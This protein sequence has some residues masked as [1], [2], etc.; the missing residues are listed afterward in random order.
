MIDDAAR[1][2]EHDRSRTPWWTPHPVVLEINTWVWLGEIAERDGRT[3]RLGDVPPRDW[4]YLAAWGLDAVWL[5]GVWERSPLG[6]QITLADPVVMDE[7]RRALPGLTS[8]DVAGSPYSI[9][10]YEVDARLGGRA[11]LAAARAAL[12]ARGIALILD[13]VPNHV[14][15]DHPWVAESPS[16]FI[17]GNAIDLAR[18]PD[19]FIALGGVVLARGRDPWFQPWKDTVQLNAFDPGLRAAA[20]A[21]LLDI[22]TQCDG[23]RCDMA[24]LV[25]SDVFGRTWAGRAGSPPAAEFWTEMIDPVRGARPDFRFIAEAYWEREWA[26][27][28]LDFDWCYDKGLYDRLV[29]GDAESV[30]RDLRTEH[31]RGMRLVRFIENHDEPRAAAMLPA[32]RHRAA[33]VIA[34]MQSGMRL[35]H[36]GQFEGRRVRIPV[37]LARRPAEQPDEQILLFHRRLLATLRSRP[38]HEGEWRLCETA[39]WEDHIAHRHLVA[40]SW[41]VDA[42]WMLIVV[43]YSDAAALGRV[44]LPWAEIGGRGWTLIDTLGDAPWDRDGLVVRDD[45]LLV[46]LPPWGMHC[47]TA[48]AVPAATGARPA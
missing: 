32:G 34:G 31:E 27:Q 35:F 45:G 29:T 22:A 19:E 14:A 4:D 25:L 40:W 8:D 1:E 48:T 28:R 17:H 47:F 38:L 24:M 37:Q 2:R 5:M 43:N 41:R 15:P 6:R 13:F 39:A 20:R 46:E 26:L 18:A 7:L 30:V 21:T 33:T 16:F 10:R 11:G 12:A 23:V 44:Y 3:V 42:E 36:E 9:R